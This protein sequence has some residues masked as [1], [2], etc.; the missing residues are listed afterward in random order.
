M[1]IAYRSKSKLSPTNTVF[2]ESLNQILDE[3]A[4]MG[5]ILTLRQLYYQL[6]SRDIIAN[7]Q[8]EYQKLSVTLGK[9][10][11]AGLVDWDAIEDRVR[12]PR[13]PYWQTDIQDAITDAYRTY[14][15]DRQ[16]YQNTYVEVWVEKDALSNI[17]YK[18]TSKYHIRLMVNRG[19][20][21][22]SA[23]HEAYK[24]IQYQMDQGKDCTILYFGDHDPSGLDMVRDIRERLEEFGAELLT[25]QIALN[26]DQ[27]RKYNP[28]TNPAKIKDPR[29]KW[30]IKEYGNKSWEL[31]ALR[32]D[33]LEELIK[34]AI[35]S[36]IDV[37]LYKKAYNEEREEAGRLLKLANIT[38]DHADITELV[39]TAIKQSIKAQKETTIIDRKSIETPCFIKFDKS[40]G[41]IVEEVMKSL[42]IE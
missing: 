33:V 37:D 23:M 22:I 27:V 9:A 25:D 18:V 6:V 20:S 15:I 5:Y 40:D 24:R 38:K 32:P 10:R 12:I 4:E 26:M 30:Y 21:S 1:K 28:P 35:E 2:V 42:N 3:Y 8:R 39:R 11:M 31:D 16:K 17:F 41:E 29:A 36:I 13:V 19:Y 7:S 14:R 34:S